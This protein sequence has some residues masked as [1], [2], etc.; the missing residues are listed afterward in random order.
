[1]SGRAVLIL[2]ATWLFTGLSFCQVFD[3]TQSSVS[4]PHGGLQDPG[5]TSISGL[6]TG[7]DGAPVADAHIELRN[8][9]TGQTVVSAYT[10]VGGSFQFSNFPPGQYELV[11]TLGLSEARQHLTVN[12]VGANLKIRL[13]TSNAAAAQADGNSTVSVAEYKVPQKARDAFHKAQEAM[14]KN[15][16]EE[17]GKQLTKA[18]DI[19]PDYAP[20]LTLRGVLSLDANKTQAA[21]DDFDKA[22]HSDPGLAMAYTGMAAAMNQLHKFDDA[23]RS[24]GQA[25]ALAPR[26]WQSYF[27]MAKAYIGK[28][29]YRSALVQLSKAQE[30][31]TTD[32]APIHLVRAHALVAVQEYKDAM[33]ELQAFLTLAPNDPNSEMAR[34]ALE[35]IKAFTAASAKPAIAVK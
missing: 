17:A 6:V 9:H 5:I 8:E 16:P 4:G 10:N 28:T 12:D 3:P 15:R 14:A 24:A 11:A 26:A 7:S 33:S 27:E 25:V 23:V 20:A 21:V 19:Y 30:F 2:I 1:M 18:L 35:K 32:Y 29:D 22:I 31:E 13:N 34:Q